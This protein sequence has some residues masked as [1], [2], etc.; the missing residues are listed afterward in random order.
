[1][2]QFFLKVC[3][4]VTKETEQCNILVYEWL[5]LLFAA[6]LCLYFYLLYCLKM[7]LEFFFL[8]IIFSIH[9]SQFYCL[10]PH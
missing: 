2:H 4:T 7:S 6:M 1:M 5:V 9:V 8:K 3:D 10:F